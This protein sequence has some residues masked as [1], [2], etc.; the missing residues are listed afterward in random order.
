MF[1]TALSTSSWTLPAHMSMLTG[2]LPE[3]HGV[4]KERKVLDARRALVQEILHEGGFRTAGVV[5][6]AFLDGRY[7]FERGFESYENLWT[8]ESELFAGVP[9]GLPLVALLAQLQE[10]VDRK[11]DQDRTG[12]KVVEAANRWLD[13]HASESFFLFVHFWEPHADYIAPS[14]YDR[15]FVPPQYAGTLSMKNFFYN[16]AINPNMAPEDLAYLLSQYDGEIA[17][18]D[19]LIGKI[20]DRLDDLGIADETLVVVTSDHGEE[21]FEHGQKGHRT[22]LYR[23]SVRVPLILRG[24]GV[25]PNPA[26]ISGPIV[27]LIDLA[28]TILSAVGMEPG[29]EMMGRDLGPLL[30]GRPGGQTTTLRLDGPDDGTRPGDTIAGDGTDEAPDNLL[31]SPDQLAVCQLVLGDE[32]GEACPQFAVRSDRWKAIIDCRD[33]CEIYDLL[34]DPSEQEPISQSNEAEA[35]QFLRQC[36]RMRTE[37][38]RVARSIPHEGTKLLSIDPKLEEELRS[39][40]YMK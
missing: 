38:R 13:E 35:V 9:K 27:S 1:R 22:A 24:P 39:L 28:P 2:L 33:S 29:P 3:V 21:F 7:G 32:S 26:G 23:E 10:Q 37:V 12:P 34:R 20:L 36:R 17:F 14:P 25:V 30:A 16:D 19:F 15:F 5:S 11:A 6:A 40:G 8:S 18:T 31:A 4:Q